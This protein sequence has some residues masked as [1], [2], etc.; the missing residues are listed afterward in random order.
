MYNKNYKNEKYKTLN[1]RSFYKTKFCPFG[2]KCHFRH[3]F[4]AL[5]RLHRHFHMAHLNALRFTA[6]EILV[7]STTQPDGGDLYLN[8]CKELGLEEESNIVKNP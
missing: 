4:R 6:Q 7:E 3:D 8:F 2:D 1:C 5:S